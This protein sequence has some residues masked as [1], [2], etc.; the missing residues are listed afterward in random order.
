MSIKS[1]S[2]FCPKMYFFPVKFLIRV[3]YKG[4]FPNVEYELYIGNLEVHSW[5]RRCHGSRRAAQQ[6]LFHLNIIQ[7]SFY[8]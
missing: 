4:V 5:Q 7:F 3:L 6:L 8:V 2:D 1:Q